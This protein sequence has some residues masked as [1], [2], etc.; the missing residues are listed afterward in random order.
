MIARRAEREAEMQRKQVEARAAVEQAIIP[1]R[2]GLS[3]I[4]L[5]SRLGLSSWTAM[6]PH[7]REMKQVNLSSTRTMDVRLI[8]LPGR[9]SRALVHGPLGRA[10]ARCGVTRVRVSDSHCVTHEVKNP[11]IRNMIAHRSKP[12]MVATVWTNQERNTNVECAGYCAKQRHSTTRN[13]R[14][15]RQHP[16]RQW[17]WQLQ[18]KGC[19]IDDLSRLVAAPTRLPSAL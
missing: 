8:P 7:R 14:R 17:K 3:A 10:P 18:L 16:A 13:N 19:D 5:T 9:W 15:H 11:Y 2:M 4:R 1:W 12:T 6:Y